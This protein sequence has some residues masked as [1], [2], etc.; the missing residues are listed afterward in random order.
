MVETRNFSTHFT[1]WNPTQYKLDLVKFADKYETIVWLDSDV[2][3]YEDMT[4]LLHEFQS[5]PKQYAF[6][7]DHVMLTKNFTKDGQEIKVECTFHKR[8]SCA[9]NPSQ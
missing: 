8:V 4:S 6:T 9:S 7:K 1:N 2:I 5:S 3:V